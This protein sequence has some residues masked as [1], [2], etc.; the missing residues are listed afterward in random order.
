MHTPTYVCIYY[1]YIYIYMCV[2]VWREP[3]TSL[4]NDLSSCKTSAT[5][6]FSSKH[7][8]TMSHHCLQVYKHRA[9][10]RPLFF[11][12]QPT[13]CFHMLS[14]Y[15]WSLLGMHILQVM[16]FRLWPRLFGPLLKGFSSDWS[17]SSNS[18]GASMC[19]HGKLQAICSC[20]LRQGLNVC[21]A[22]G[23]RKNMPSRGVEVLGPKINITQSCV[24]KKIMKIL[25]SWQSKTPGFHWKPRLF[26]L[27][28]PIRFDGFRFHWYEMYSSNTLG[29]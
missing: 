24:I 13:K 15:T 9:S 3:I 4:S 23:R 8:K 26:P 7:I 19:Y 2:C 6:Y 1:V 27:D 21:E 22:R 12:Q 5:R 29:Y 18:Q 11:G 20:R 25:K 14:K 17:G 16:P 10:Q 28:C